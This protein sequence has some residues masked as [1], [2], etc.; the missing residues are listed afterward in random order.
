MKVL[1]VIPARWGS[2]RFPGKSLHPIAEKPLVQWVWERASQARALDEVVVATDDERIQR[3]VEGF[4][5]TVVMTRADHPSGTDR[6]AE[7]AGALGG[8]V[9]IN[10]QGDEPLIDPDL[11]DRLAGFLTDEPGWN[12]ATAATPFQSLEQ[13]LEPGAVKVVFGEQDRALYFSRSVI[14]HDRDGDFLSAANYW[15]HLGIYAYQ[16]TFLEKLVEAPPCPLEQAEKL[17]QLRALH[18]GCRMKIVRT[19]DTGVGVDAPED[20]PRAEEALREAG[21]LGM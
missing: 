15:R 8:D 17:E 10:V 21:L 13:V 19:L 14:P 12:M 16:R 18:L 1:G 20:V 4:G 6:V 2:T 11:I 9:V 3:A 7:V 5:G